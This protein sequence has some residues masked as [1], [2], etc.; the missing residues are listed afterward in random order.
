M[1]LK[2]S[3]R[4]LEPLRRTGRRRKESNSYQDDGK[5]VHAA[6]LANNIAPDY[7]FA[8]PRCQRVSVA[9]TGEGATMCGSCVESSKLDPLFALGIVGVKPGVALRL[10]YAGRDPA[11][12]LNSRVRG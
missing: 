12:A 9:N 5:A 11:L 6:I 2:D 1:L 10:P 7:P 4:F 3:V 8:V